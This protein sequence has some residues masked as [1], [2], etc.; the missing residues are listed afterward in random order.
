MSCD[1]CYTYLWMRK[2]QLGSKTTLDLWN[3]C[4]PIFLGIFSAF[5]GHSNKSAV[6]K[7]NDNGYSSCKYKWPLATRSPKPNNFI[8]LFTH[9]FW[10]DAHFLL[11]VRMHALQRPFCMRVNN[12]HTLNIPAIYQLQRIYPLTEI[13]IIWLSSVI[14]CFEKSFSKPSTVVFC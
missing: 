1:T 4:V 7:N 3:H 14:F 5:F 8:G 9:F 13:I 10:I 6:K 2:Q 12:I 11:L